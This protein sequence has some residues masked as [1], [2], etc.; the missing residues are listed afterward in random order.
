LQVEA[1]RVRDSL[2]LAGLRFVLVDVHQPLAFGERVRQE[3]RVIQNAENGI[4]GAGAGREHR[5][6]AHAESPVLR[7]APNGVSAVATQRVGRSPPKR[8]A[9]AAHWHWS[10]RLAWLNADRRGATRDY[11]VGGRILPPATVPAGLSAETATPR[12]GRSQDFEKNIAVVS[13]HLS[14]T[15]DFDPLRREQMPCEP[16]LREGALRLRQ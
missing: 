2:R 1:G 15:C 13:R 12:N 16:L 6:R 14:A 3:Q 8:I 9:A 5:N 7:Q 10:H 4:V 11:S